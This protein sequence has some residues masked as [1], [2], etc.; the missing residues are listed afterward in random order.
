MFNISITSEEIE[1]M[2]LGAFPGE[3]TVIEKTGIEYLRAVAYLMSQKVI[4]FDT[5]TR[6]VFSPG[7]PHKHVALLQL[8]G[9]DKAFL[10]RTNMIGVKSMMASI[11]C[12]PKIIKVGA[13]VHDDIRGL[14]YYRKFVAQNFV[15]L[16]KIVWEWGIKEKSVKKMAGIILGCKISKTQQLS[17]WEAPKLSAAQQMYAATDAW[18]CLEMYKKLLSSKKNPLRPEQF[19]VVPSTQ[20]PKSDKNNGKDNTEKRTR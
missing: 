16:Q 14:Q 18:I 4:G 11:L 17:N 12:N 7:Q 19:M 2:P 13:A 6:P 5:E 8:S 20:T 1:K 15:D 10:F 3:I 9:P